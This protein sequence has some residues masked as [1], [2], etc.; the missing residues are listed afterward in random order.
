[1]NMPVLSIAETPITR[2]VRIEITLSPALFD[3][4]TADRFSCHAVTATSI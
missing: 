2:I 3:S 4:S 1:V